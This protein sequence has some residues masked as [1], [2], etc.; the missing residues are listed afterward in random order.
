M[1]FPPNKANLQIKA[2][3][4]SV[5]T[6]KS[7]LKKLGL[8]PEQVR[9]VDWRTKI[10]EVLGDDASLSPVQNQGK[11]G[12]CWAVSSTSAFTDRFMI[13]KKIKNLDLTPI[14]ATVCAGMPQ[15]QSLGCGGG[16]PSDAGVYFQQ[17]GCYNTN[18]DCLGLDTGMSVKDP[19]C[20]AHPGTSECADNVILPECKDI[21]GSC[22]KNNNIVYKVAG[23]NPQNV[24]QPKSVYSTVTVR[25]NT[26]DDRWNMLSMTTALNDGPIVG[27]FNVM[28]DFYEGK[29]ANTNGIYINGQYNQNDGSQNLG[30]H[31]VE[32][33]G[34]GIEKG[35]INIKNAS[36]IIQN[37]KDNDPDIKDYNR[38][39]NTCKMYN[40]PYWIIK[41]SWGT[42][43]ADNGYC[44]F[45][46]YDIRRKYSGDN[47]KTVIGDQLI[48]NYDRKFNY[49][50]Y[51][52][53]PGEN[54]GLGGGTVFVVDTSTGDEKDTEFKPYPNAPP[55]KTEE[56]SIN[57]LF[58]L[59]V[60]IG[61]LL[62]LWM[63]L[64][65][66]KSKK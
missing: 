3:K 4:T 57:F 58:L 33:V 13:S 49:N 18:T 37:V 62:F 51:L 38:E 61:V 27:C 7:N 16:F 55:K 47:S 32:I 63:I 9:P 25:G 43:W 42:H 64:S 56:R 53:M 11:C 23:D 20:Q 19:N 29:W 12:N 6:L 21:V 5:D 2:P 15:F 8:L 1:N 60:G 17:Y 39:S 45:A 66:K 65:D 41:N 50:T 30:G 44:K 52:D 54:G 31:A 36:S 26:F 48:E 14:I 22:K 24:T 28:K 10:K 35:P 46:M 34:W 59:L 40:I